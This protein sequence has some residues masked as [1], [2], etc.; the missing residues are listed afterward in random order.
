[1]IAQR[2]MRNMLASGLSLRAKTKETIDVLYESAYSEL[3]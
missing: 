3:D 2:K 1:M